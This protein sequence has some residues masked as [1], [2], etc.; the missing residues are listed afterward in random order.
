MYAAAPMTFYA[1]K[2]VAVIAVVA[3]L[4]ACDDKKPETTSAAAS[5]SATAAAPSPAPTP[6]APTKPQLAVDD[7]A[8]FVAGQ[9]IEIAKP[10]LKGRVAAVLSDKPVAG[11]ELVL[12]AARPT[13]IPKVAAVF[14]ALIAKKA[15]SVEV[16]TP[17]RDG[18]DGHVTFGLTVKPSDCSAVGFIAKDNAITVWPVSGAAADRFNHGMA[19][20][21][22][23]RGSEGL[24]KKTL[25]CDSP[26]FFVAADDSITWGL[27]YDLAEATLSADDAG[28]P[29]PRTAALLVKTPVS[30][31]K[32]DVDFVE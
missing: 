8:V 18:S 9:R 4:A 23:T 21:D 7:T 11:E 17:R 19:G 5:T 32:A 13:K 28:L 24:R 27:T 10:D 6:T 12:N 31:R 3:A 29:K 15:K 2:S 16:H 1:D 26:V 14:A 22:L 30:G 20:P 25:A